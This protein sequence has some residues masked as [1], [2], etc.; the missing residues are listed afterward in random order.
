LIFLLNTPQEVQEMP[1]KGISK[2]KEP[3]SK[4]AFAENFL[5]FMKLAAGMID[6]LGEE[7]AEVIKAIMEWRGP[8]GLKFDE[9][10][11]RLIWIMHRLGHHRAP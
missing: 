8:G 6:S 7:D 4:E 11:A 5:S 3:G 9:R 2:A 1:D 10:Q